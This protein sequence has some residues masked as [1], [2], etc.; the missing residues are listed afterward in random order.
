MKQRWNML[1]PGLLYAGAAVGVSHL[2][3]S[4]RAGADFGF[5]LVWILIIAN[6]V[7]YPFFEFGPRYAAA[8]GKNLIEGYASLGRWALWLFALL[9]IATMFSI[10]AAVTAVTA[11]IFAHIFHISLSPQVTFALVILSAMLLLIAGKYQILDKAIKIVIVLLALSTLMAVILG[12]QNGY[13][14]DPAMAGSFSWVHPLHIFFLIAFI[15]WMPAPI[16]VSVWHS[17]WG[18]AKQ[19]SSK[20]KPSLR[21]ALLDFRIG[22]IGTAFLALCFLSLG[23]L[24]MHGSGESLSDKG[25]VFAG[26]LMGMYTA[27][28]GQWTYPVIAIAALTTMVSTTLTALDAYPRVI[29]SL[30]KALY[31]ER[32]DRKKEKQLYRTT[33]LILVAG[34][35][36]LITY[37]SSSMRFLVDMATTLSFITAPLIA[38]LN[39]KVI[40]GNSVPVAARPPRWLSLYSVGGIILISGFT[41]FYILWSLLH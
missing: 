27:S 37:L 15:G 16:D 1:G 22:Y 18:V 19:Q 17:L 4:T 7:K 34:S 35:I 41:G 9:T 5:G 3:Q 31:P 24:V 11:G 26:Q 39:H 14:P 38:I 6:L 23:A 32:I 29:Q 10:Q 13:H 8:T 40:H 20:H 30:G 25:A 21:Q 28:L 2:V 12:M 36:M 33:M